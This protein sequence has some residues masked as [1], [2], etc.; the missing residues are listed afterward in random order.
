MN[1]DELT[2]IAAADLEYVIGGIN[3]G[4]IAQ[5]IGGLVDRFTGGSKGTEIAGQIAGI[6]QRFGGEGSSGGGGGGGGGGG[7]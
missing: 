6:A 5:K 1:H 7:W 4:G 2:S 3:I